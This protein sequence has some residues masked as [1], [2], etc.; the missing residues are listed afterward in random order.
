MAVKTLKANASASEKDCFAR[1]KE[2]LR[3]LE[4]ECAPNATL[5]CISCVQYLTCQH[6]ALLKYDLSS[7]CLQHG[8]RTEAHYPI[9]VRRNI[10]GY[11][12]QSLPHVL[13]CSPRTGAQADCIVM[14]LLA[15]GTAALLHPSLKALH[16]PLS[17]HPITC[18]ADPVSQSQVR[19]H[20]R[21]STRAVASARQG[22]FSPVLLQI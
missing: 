14:E 22:C 15:G 6:K 20:P 9:F 4:H 2:I 1:E 21:P 13:E 5:A 16:S 10:V 18:C 11:R 12:G 19:D 7:V 17:V 8:A 3:K